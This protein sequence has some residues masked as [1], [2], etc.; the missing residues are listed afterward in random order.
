LFLS[1]LHFLL[2]LLLLLRQVYGRQHQGEPVSYSRVIKQVQQQGGFKGFYTGILPE[3]CKVV[4]GVAIA[5]C[6]YEQLKKWLQAQ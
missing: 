1:L 6:T 5:F 2:L 4:P 3:Y